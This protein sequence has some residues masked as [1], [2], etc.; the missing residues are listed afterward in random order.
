M[1][2]DQR[3]GARLQE[4]MDHLR[5]P[6]PNVADVA[7]RARRFRVRR[8][9]GLAAVTILAAVGITV[10]LLVLSP[11]AQHEPSPGSAASSTRVSGEGL[12][13]DLRDGWDGRIYY[14]PDAGERVLQFANLPLDPVPPAGPEDDLASRTR[15]GMGPGD[16]V[17]VL[18]ELTY[19]PCAGFQHRDLACLQRRNRIT[20]AQQDSI[21]GDRRDPWARRQNTDE[22]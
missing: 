17:V 8:R 3:M 12:S 20:V 5:A 21:R 15:G 22:V 19:C 18:R 10:P 1:S 6:A 2:D 4:G 14:N 9:A 13:I 7:R 16:V 11:L